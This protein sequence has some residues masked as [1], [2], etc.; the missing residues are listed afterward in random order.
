MHIFDICFTLETEETGRR[1]NTAHWNQ[2]FQSVIR[3]FLVVMW[4][5]LCYLCAKVF[6]K[7][8]TCIV[9]THKMYLKVQGARILV[10][11]VQ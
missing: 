5:L 11:D 2:Q 10:E 8:K 7:S 4:L 6:W 1:V 9:T 3:A